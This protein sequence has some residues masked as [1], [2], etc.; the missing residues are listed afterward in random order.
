MSKAEEMI[1]SF[2]PDTAEKFYI[3][4]LEMEPNNTDVMD[5]YA[6]LLLDMDDWDR[7]KQVTVLGA[8]TNMCISC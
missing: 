7:A 8:C 2:H 3:K 5:A 4:A 1:Q 6:A